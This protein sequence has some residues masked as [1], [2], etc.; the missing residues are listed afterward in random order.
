MNTNYFGKVNNNIFDSDNNDDCYFSH[1][2]Y[3]NGF[4]HLYNKNKS[5][6][7]Y[8]RKHINNKSLNNGINS[9]RVEHSEIIKNNKSQDINKDFSKIETI[10]IFKVKSPPSK[11]K[12]KNQIFNLKKKVYINNNKKEE[13]LLYNNI[14]KRKKRN[15]SNSS[16]DEINISLKKLSTKENIPKINSQKNSNNKYKTIEQMNNINIFLENKNPKYLRNYYGKNLNFNTPIKKKKY[17]IKNNKYLLN[18]LIVVNE[19]QFSYINNNENYKKKIIFLKKIIYN[20]NI[21]IKILRQQNKI[22]IDKI[23]KMYEENVGTLE[24]INSLK[25]DF[26][27]SNYNKNEDKVK[28]NDINIKHY[29]CSTEPNYNS[30]LINIKDNILN[31]KRVIYCLY[32]NNNLLSYDFINNQFKLNSIINEDFQKEFNK[33]INTLYC[34]NNNKLYI[35][36]GN[37]NDQLFIYNINSKKIK[38]YSQLKN[39]HIF[40]SLIFFSNNNNKGKETL[41]C[42]SGKYNKKVE[43]YNDESDYWNDKII[44]EM[45]EERCNSYYLII[46]NNYIYGFYG[47]NYILQKYLNNIVYYDLKY[48]KWNKILNNSLYNNNKGIKNH[49][50][51]ENK[52]NKRIYILGGDS[53]CNNIIIDLEKKNIVKMDLDKEIKNNNEIL[54][55][56]FA[57]YINNNV[58]AIFDNHFNIHIIDTF[59]NES[60]FIEYELI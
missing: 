46:N 44:E 48:N 8:I 20:Q 58:Y 5:N 15:I 12:I 43:I 35:I 1:L 36:A 49:F 27:Y 4:G 29:N 6:N 54:L 52:N 21:N 60:Q 39:N 34:F 11:E 22:L 38:K 14:T 10:S 30:M 32:D 37:N 17:F 50:C 23:K 7:Y 55:Y 59:A 19:N 45:P 26:V 57:Y 18:K 28:D 3:S 2:T 41:I 56:N 16:I 53:N 25:Y 42:L 40:G 9:S 33:E 24:A 13:V 47:Y 31:T 51:Y